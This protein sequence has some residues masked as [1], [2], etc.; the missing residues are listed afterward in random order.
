MANEGD[1]GLVV[2]SGP[3]PR[4]SPGV[5]ALRAQFF[6]S[7]FH[8]EASLLEAGLIRDPFLESKCYG[9]GVSLPA[10][11]TTL[12]LQNLIDN[13]GGKT[14]HASPLSY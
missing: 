11:G 12:S 3:Q 14:V 7:S 8:I 13:R 10:D 5:G 4:L 1:T 2:T 9:D 6:G